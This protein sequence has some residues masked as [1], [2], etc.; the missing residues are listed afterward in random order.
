MAELIPASEAIVHRD[1]KTSYVMPSNVN[2][3]GLFDVPSFDDSRTS[4]GKSNQAGNLR[5]RGSI[6]E[7]FDAAQKGTLALR[8]LLD[9]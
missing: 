2:V 3:V 9:E 6:E 1:G 8:S 5:A 4:F 7:V